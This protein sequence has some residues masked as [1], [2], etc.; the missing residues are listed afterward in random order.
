MSIKFALL[1]LLGE[2]PQGSAQLQATFH[3]RTDNTWPL[4][5]GQV[6]QTVKRLQ[7]D[8]LIEV[9]GREG[10]ADIFSLTADGKRELQ[11]WLA[12]AV[13]KPADDRDELVIRM[14]VV[15]DRG[16]LIKVQR[17]ANMARLRKLTRMQ[18][19]GAAELLKQRQIFD[20]EAEARWLDYLEEQS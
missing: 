4:N 2:Q 15:Q 20:L 12:T 10:K 9:T 11:E 13:E 6:Y 3:E 19:E 17:E 16:P 18:A 7:R 14:A 1:S 8:A 5:I